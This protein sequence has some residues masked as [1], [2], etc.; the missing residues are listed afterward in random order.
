MHASKLKGFLG[1]PC[2]MHTGK[3]GIHSMLVEVMLERI[4]HVINLAL[5]RRVGVVPGVLHTQATTCE[6][7]FQK[8]PA[9]EYV[10]LTVDWDTH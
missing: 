8:A 9:S 7:L 4:P 6:N 3:D 2:I 10:C 1:E 5:V